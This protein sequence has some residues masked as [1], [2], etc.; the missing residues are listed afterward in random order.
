[1]T[2][3]PGGQGSVSDPPIQVLVV[4]DDELVRRMLVKV[5]ERRGFVTHAAADGHSALA[6]LGEVDVDIVLLDQGLPD[7]SGAEVLAALRASPATATLPVIL[8]TGQADI[9]ARVG[10]LQAGADDYLVKPV[11]MDELVARV[12]AQIR[13]RDAWRSQVQDKLNERAQLAGALAAIDPVTDAAVVAAQVVGVLCR[14]PDVQR[15]RVLAP[16]GDLE[17][18]LIATSEFD[19]SHPVAPRPTFDPLVVAEVRQVLARGAVLLPSVLANAVFEGATGEVVAMG[20]E[21]GGRAVA[22][23]VL[24]TAHSSDGD[25]GSP[26]DVLS[27]AIDLS[28]IVERVLTPA[29]QSPHGDISVATRLRTVIAEVEFHPVYQ[30][31]V[32]LSDGHITGFEALTRFD[33]GT[34]P[35]QR[36]AEAAHAGLGSELEL[37]TLLRALE[38]SHRLP[39]GCYLSVNVS[40]SLLVGHELGPILDL[41]GDRGSCSSSPST[42]ASM[43]TPTSARPW[44]ACHAT[45]VCRSTTQD[46]GGRACGTSSR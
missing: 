26:L 46:R 6:L 35:D 39:V 12:H 11:N 22:A 33:D 13:G 18:R 7:I 23:I 29:F 17:V 8:V 25:T 15:I 27:A 24:E 34:P 44:H 14:I 32:E 38:V 16:A 4:D 40:A 5:L 2:T 31:I 20:V 9:E 43:T 42:S 36:F 21:I 45:S 19:V 41:A 37:A 10:G 30:P 3:G 1:M 28:P